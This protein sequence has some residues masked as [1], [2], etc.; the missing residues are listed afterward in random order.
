VDRIRALLG[1]EAAE[2]IRA[3]LA[4]L[5]LLLRARQ[6]SAAKLGELAGQISGYIADPDSLLDV[7][8]MKAGYE[9]VQRAYDTFERQ[10][11]AYAPLRQHSRRAQGRGRR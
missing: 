5:R 7:A 10:L 8:P 6:Q 2:K 11:A 3:W 4:A 9:A 1:V